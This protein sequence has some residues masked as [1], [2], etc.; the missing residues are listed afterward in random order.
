VETGVQLNDN[1]LSLLDSGFRRNDE[2]RQFRSSYEAVNIVGEQNYNKLLIDM[3]FSPI[4]P[5]NRPTASR[6]S[7]GLNRPGKA[8]FSDSPFQL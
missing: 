4:M 1:E 3:I 2:Q 5:R 6:G 7:Y 8:A